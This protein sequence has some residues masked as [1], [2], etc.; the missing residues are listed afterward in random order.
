MR[1]YDEADPDICVICVANN[2]YGLPKDEFYD[3]L[4]ETDTQFFTTMDNGLITFIVDDGEYKVD[5]YK[6]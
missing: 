6:N 3:V 1:L 5:T 2:S 4:Y